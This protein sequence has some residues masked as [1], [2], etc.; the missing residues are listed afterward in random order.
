MNKIETLTK[1][2]DNMLTLTIVNKFLAHNNFMPT[3]LYTTSVNT[4]KTVVVV[5]DKSQKEECSRFIKK[6]SSVYTKCFRKNNIQVSWSP[7]N[8]IFFALRRNK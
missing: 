4:R 3:E 2:G 5:Y 8:R 1:H 6:A 7:N